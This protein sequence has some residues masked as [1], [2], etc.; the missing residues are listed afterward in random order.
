MTLAWLHINIYL[1]IAIYSRCAKKG[2]VLT[3]SKAISANNP[4]FQ[5]STY[6]WD[7]FDNKQWMTNFDENSMALIILQYLYYYWTIKAR[8]NVNSCITRKTN[9]TSCSELMLAF[10]EIFKFVF[11]LP[12]YK[13][14][15]IINGIESHWFCIYRSTGLWLFR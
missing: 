7:V 12:R 1:S 10:E 14:G 13:A 9:V 3:L 11:F 8:R 6:Q 4:S 5:Y 2:V 15:L